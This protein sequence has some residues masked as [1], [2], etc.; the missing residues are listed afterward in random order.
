MW[1]VP[2]DSHLLFGGFD[3]TQLLFYEY[4]SV[5]MYKYMF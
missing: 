3:Y 2:G 4:H 1:T 5:L